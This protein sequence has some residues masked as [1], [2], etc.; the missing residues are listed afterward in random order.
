MPDGLPRLLLVEDDPTSRAF[1]SAAL[2]ALPAE[3]D[4]ADSLA[5]ATALAQTQDYALWLIDARLPDGSGAELLAR[6]RSRHPHTPALAHTAAHEPAILEALV[7]AGFAE[8][9]VK[10]LPATAVQTAVRSRLGLSTDPVAIP[11]TDTDGPWPV[12]DDA[13]A[14]QALNG[15][16]AHVDT[17]RGLFAQELPRSLQAITA[18]ATRGDAEAVRADLHRLRASCGFVGA[19]RLAAA[20]QA[21]QQDALSATLLVRFEQAAHET[22]PLSVASPAT[23]SALS[24]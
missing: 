16:R 24:D 8:V 13:A 10:P 5:A 6:L 14:V 7:A 2:R 9:L 21:L 18:A 15:N 22:L 19:A 20:V 4:A 17:L 12:W 11:T 3:V 1:L 23:Q